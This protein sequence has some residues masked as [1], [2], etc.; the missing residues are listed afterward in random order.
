MKV[1]VLLI[2][3]ISEILFSST[4]KKNQKSLSDPKSSKKTFASQRLSKRKTKTDVGKNPIIYHQ[5]DAREK[6]TAYIIH[7][8][9]LP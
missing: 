5:E 4:L 3:K 6:L 7:F 9:T 1:R 2:I 8:Q